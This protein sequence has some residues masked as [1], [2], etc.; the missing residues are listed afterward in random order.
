[1]TT[2]KDLLED[3]R[4]R[5]EKHRQASE[6]LMKTNIENMMKKEEETRLYE[7]LNVENNALKRKLEEDADTMHEYK[8]IKGDIARLHNQLTKMEA[9]CSQLRQSKLEIVRERE[10]VRTL[11]MDADRQLAILKAAQCM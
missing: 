2:H 1:M 10:E 7:L 6:K 11:F 4:L 8:R 5:E 3:S 9:E